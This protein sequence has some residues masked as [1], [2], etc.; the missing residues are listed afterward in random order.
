MTPWHIHLSIA[1]IALTIAL[2]SFGLGR[3]ATAV[4]GAAPDVLEVQGKLAV[5]QDLPYGAI[6]WIDDKLIL[7]VVRAE[8][9][10]VI[11][12]TPELV[13]RHHQAIPAGQAAH[14]LLSPLIEQRQLAGGVVAVMPRGSP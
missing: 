6:A 10:P 3:A 12:V 8:V 2:V 5:P 1:G 9:L 7:R 13:E 4:F 14:L 11:L